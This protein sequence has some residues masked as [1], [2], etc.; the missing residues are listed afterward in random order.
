[1]TQQTMRLVLEHVVC[2]DRCSSRSTAFVLG[3]SVTFASTLGRGFLTLRALS[4]NLAGVPEQAV[5]TDNPGAGARACDEAMEGHLVRILAALG[6]T[7]PQDC[8]LLIGTART[9][10]PRLPRSGAWSPWARTRRH[11]ATGD[12][13]DPR[14]SGFRGGFL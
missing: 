12:H 9:V 11:V 3:K 8:S 5:H 10:L 7:T 4:R 2:S 13:G 6:E 1:M 14:L